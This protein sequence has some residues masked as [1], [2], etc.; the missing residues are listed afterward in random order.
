MTKTPEELTEEWKA[1]K[2]PAG[3]YYLNF[4]NGE[5]ELQNNCI[6]GFL[7]S[8]DNKVMQ[9]LAP[10]P[11][12]DEYKAMQ[13]QIADQRAELESARWYQTVQNE[14]I[15][16]LRGLLKDIKLFFE[17]CNPHDFTEDEIEK[18]GTLGVNYEF[19]H[20][21][22]KNPENFN[23]SGGNVKGDDR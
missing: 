3:W 21:M 12:Y 1:G 23:T 7:M 6:G 5:I 8:R 13:E 18:I 19:V 10:V 2:L 9:V 4:E 22:L 11:T 17:E 16:K 15:G 14:D 20:D